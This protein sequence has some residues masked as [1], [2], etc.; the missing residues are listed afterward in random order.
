MGLGSGTNNYAEL[1]VLKLLLCLAIERNCTNLQIL[2]DSLVVINQIN[3][4]QRCRNTSL[5]ALVEEVSRLLANFDSLSLKHVYME[6][7]MEANRLSK[8]G[9]SLAWGTWKIIE[10]RRHGSMSTII[11]HFWICRNR[12]IFC[13]S[14]TKPNRFFYLS[15]K[16]IA[17][18]LHFF[19]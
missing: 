10:K 13:S 14:I 9:I 16:F 11:G 8:A 3:K 1:M 2:G 4:T 18:L 5:D 17:H 12:K 19:S 6:R 15:K 7:N